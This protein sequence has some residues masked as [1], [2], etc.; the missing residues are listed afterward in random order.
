MFRSGGGVGLA[1]DTHFRCAKGGNV[2]TQEY[3]ELQRI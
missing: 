2:K 3:T 1:A